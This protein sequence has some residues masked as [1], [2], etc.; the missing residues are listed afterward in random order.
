MRAGIYTLGDFQIGAAGTQI[1]ATID[2]MEGVS[3]IDVQLR[4]AYGSGGTS[5]KVY[6]QT[7]LDQGQT[8]LDLWCFAAATASKTRLRHLAPT[9]GEITPTDG[10]LADDTVAAG[11]VLGDRFR[12]K[13]ISTGTFTGQSLLSARMHVR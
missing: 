13:L 10:A 1:S 2:R 4:F 6:L 3:S 5:L 7:S 9:A 12:L 11:V 8:W